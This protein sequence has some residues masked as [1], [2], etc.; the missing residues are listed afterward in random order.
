MRLGNAVLVGVAVV[1]LSAPAFGQTR[2]R[3][4]GTPPDPWLASGSFGSSFGETDGA[5]VDLGGTIG[6]LPSNRW[7]I[8]FLAGFSPNTDVAGLADTQ[9]NSYM[10]N[11]LALLPRRERWHPFV[12]AGLGAL[13]FDS[14][15]DLD[16]IDSPEDAVAAFNIGGGVMMFGEPW[17]VRG[18]LRYFRGFETDDLPFLSNLDLWRASIGFLLRW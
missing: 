14:D 15:V 11:G 9:V 3:T 2:S 8:E 5:T 10:V 12:S 18:E 16:G 4:T 1:F 7:G 17:G 13:T 6:Y